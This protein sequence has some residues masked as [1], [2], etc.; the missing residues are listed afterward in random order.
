MGFL[1]MALL[2]DA[3][4][5]GRKSKVA[6]LS[7]K[8]AQ[9]C[10][11]SPKK[12][13]SP[14]IIDLIP[15]IKKTETWITVQQLSAFASIP[16]R[17][18]KDRCKKGKYTTKFVDCNGGKAGKQY[19]I[20]LEGLSQEI[21]D[22]YHQSL[23]ADGKIATECLKSDDDLSDNQVY[24]AE[25]SLEQVQSFGQ[26]IARNLSSGGVESP[27]LQD[28][29]AF[30]SSLVTQNNDEP[31]L[32]SPLYY[33]Q[34]LT[35]IDNYPQ[36]PAQFSL[37]DLTPQELEQRRKKPMPEKAKMI[38]L[39]RY[40]LVQKFRQFKTNYKH[41]CNVQ[42]SQPLPNSC[43][44]QSS[45]EETA[46]IL[47]LVSSEKLSIRQLAEILEEPERTIKFKAE[48]GIYQA[49]KVKSAGKT[50]FKYLVWVSSLPIDVQIKYFYSNYSR[51]EIA[52]KAD[53]TKN[54]QQ[55][56]KMGEADK[57]FE[58][59][60]NSKFYEDIFNVLGKTSISTIYR[61]DKDLKTG[62][63]DYH[64]LVP[65][66]SYAGTEKLNTTLSLVEQARLMK[67]L[68]TPSQMAVETAYKYTKQMLIAEGYTDIKTVNTYRRFVDFFR[69]RNNHV[70]VICREGEKALNDKCIPS[71]QRNWDNVAPCELLVADG[72]TLDFLVINPFTGKP[73]RA[74]LV[75][76]LDVK[77]NY[78]AGF[79]IMLTENT[80]SVL[81]ALRNAI[82][83]MGRIPDY[84]YLDNGKSFKNRFFNGNKDISFDDARFC[85]V[86]GA[87]GIQT[88]Y[89][90]AYNAQAKTIERWFG[91]FTRQFEKLMKSYIGNNIVNKPAWMKRNEKLHKAMHNEFVP[92]ME[93]AMQMISV[94]IETFQSQQP[95]KKVEGKTVKEVFE[96]GKGNGVDI[97][98]LDDMMTAQ[99]KATVRRHGIRFLHAD[100]WNDR[101]FGRK[102]E[103]CIRYSLFDL[104][105]INVYSLEDEFICRA[106]R[107]EKV[108]ALAVYKGNELDMANYKRAI[109]Q[110]AKLKKDAIAQ[111]RPILQAN[112]FDNNMPAIDVQFETK[113]PKQT[114]RVEGNKTKRITTNKTLEEREEEI[115]G[116]K[117][118]QSL[119]DFYSNLY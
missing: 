118:D 69:K 50:G 48:K 3:N 62:G 24:E 114:Q 87:L 2:E 73:C 58:A 102:E 17:T 97:N 67:L 79:E 53:T 13:P 52:Y 42:L 77:S 107:V 89:A 59:L 9:L 117:L 99:Q 15:A 112:L 86:Y 14:V 94:W 56:P 65:A 32:N 33:G 61:W 31:N 78:M 6:Q 109:K 20:L 119:V 75:G 85:G 68:L 70:W 115:A 100:Y 28:P 26:T 36:K 110:Q 45:A 41:S 105:Y 40:E 66:Y 18:V 95:C 27:I 88:V 108:E 38:G 25:T 35:S 54:K 98:A 104:S 111:A 19:M 29:S 103:V 23:N 46:R 63:E 7:E 90:K 64:Q 116:R 91:D 80:Q 21:Q 74:T 4:L 96:L 1:A 16:E 57:A 47:F 60:Y 84:V 22:K 44:I 82:M 92:T 71:I 76:F 10:P 30:F 11:G 39:K 43:L 72:H 55:K 93:E 51:F 5:K 113:E 12:L 37:L 49:D 106:E 8:V 81:S 83:N 34:A 101:L